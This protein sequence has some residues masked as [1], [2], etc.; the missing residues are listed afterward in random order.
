[1]RNLLT[2]SNWYDKSVIANTY[3]SDLTEK[4][5]QDFLDII[6]DSGPFFTPVDSSWMKGINYFE[7]R[8]WL[9][10]QLKDGRE[11]TFANVPKSVYEEFIDSK[12]KGAFFN[13][14]I[15]KNYGQLSPKAKEEA[16]EAEYKKREKRLE[17]IRKE[18]SGLSPD[19]DDEKLP[20]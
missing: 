3:P 11:Y 4:E 10:I 15:R 13:K 12:S 16:A 6:E 7:P 9:T 8:E 17:E 14:I 18:R 20:F 1:M 2:S 5:Y 19:I